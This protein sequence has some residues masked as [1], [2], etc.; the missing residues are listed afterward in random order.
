MKKFKVY[1]V[2]TSYKD[3]SVERALI[4]G[5]G[6]ELCFAF[7]KNEQDIIEQCK[8][9]NALLLRQTP[10]TGKTFKALKN[11][12]VISRYGTG[13]DN[14]SI[15]DATRHGVVVTVIPDYCVGEVADHTT[16]LLFSAIRRI[17]E[18]DRAV[19]IG[20]WDLTS[21]LPISRTRGKILG[22][23]GYGKIAREV[24][25]RLSGFPF[26]FVAFDPY[27]KLDVFEKDGTL[28]IDFQKLVIISNYI[29]IHVPLTSET[30]HMFNIKVF[31]KM[32]RS[33]ILVNTS[34]GKVVDEKDLFIALKKGYIGVA[35]LDVY[36]NEPFHPGNP[37]ARLNS[38]ILSDHASWYSEE[39]QKDMQT[40]AALE[41][42]RVMTGNIP[43]N[44]VNPETLTLKSG[45]IYK[46]REDVETLIPETITAIY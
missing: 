15:Q 7:C 8:D 24:R 35:A 31:R 43:E 27:Q 30:F 33:A 28:R 20:G 14:I 17:T 41:V 45:F 21:S 9:A 29:S 26:R 13:Y 11:L 3:Y 18:R 44:P 2:E 1:V 42:V 16:A 38:V 32:R 4:E 37:L 36:E 23:V 39:S 22:L 19:R 6:G 40:K 46:S 12:Q 25:K 34:R 10:V 5:G